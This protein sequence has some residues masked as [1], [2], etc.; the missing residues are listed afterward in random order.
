MSLSCWQL[1]QRLL[2]LNWLPAGN[3][4]LDGLGRETVPWPAEC[5]AELVMAA[6]TTPY[7][8]T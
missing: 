4:D 7:Q 6:A 8:G 2:R 1:C 3:Q 5:R